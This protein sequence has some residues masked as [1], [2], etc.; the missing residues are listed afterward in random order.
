MEEHMHEN[1]DEHDDVEIIEDNVSNNKN[2][3]ADEELIIGGP[4]YDELEKEWKLDDK[5]DTELEDAEKVTEEPD[6][7]RNV[8]T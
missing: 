7:A 8:T 2:P 5:K 4:E 1:E 6:D 3:K